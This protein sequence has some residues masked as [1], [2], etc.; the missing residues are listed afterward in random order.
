MKKGGVVGEHKVQWEGRLEGTRGC[1]CPKYLVWEC[2]KLGKNTLKLG[3]NTLE[4]K[5]MIRKWKKE[6][7]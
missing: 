1:M 2:M 3:K 5:K 7:D 4:K 6:N